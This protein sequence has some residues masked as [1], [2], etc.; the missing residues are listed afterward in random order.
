M[1]GHRPNIWWSLYPFSL[2]YGI[3]VGVRNKLFDWG[4]FRSRAFPLPVICVGNLTVGGTGKT[5]HTEYLVR[6]LRH[7]FRLA[8][9]SRGYKRITKGFVLAG[10]H[11]TAGE[12]GDEPYQMFRKFPDVT[13]AVD[14]KRC[15]GIEY[16]MRADKD[17]DVIVLDDAFQHRY[18]KPGLSIVL[19]DYRRPVY[20]DLLMPAGRLREPVCGLKRA[21]M[22]VVTKCPANMDVEERKRIHRKLCLDSRQDLFFTTL[23]YGNLEPLF[24]D[25]LSRSLS[26]VQDE[27]ILLLTGIASPALLVEM[28]ETCCRK[29]VSLVYPD[30]HAFDADD[31]KKLETVFRQLPGT[32][33]LIVT[34]EKDAARLAALP[35]LPGW[36]KPYIYTLPVEVR[37]LY[38]EEE[39][40]NSKIIEY[41]RKNSRNSGF[42]QG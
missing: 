19:M 31:M 21:D 22:V 1:S 30:H 34:T 11:T 28:L 23:T 39:T 29:V 20:S 16:L 32:K 12:I 41:V 13:V 42:H 3:G 24:A 9:L 37:F 15:E 6:L 5:P 33:K 38:D 4:V 25:T 10:T 35:A 14:E 40:F 18:V 2:L 8:T 7:R 27:E 36:L 17:L 26:D